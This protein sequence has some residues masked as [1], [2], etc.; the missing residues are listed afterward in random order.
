[1]RC[2]TEDSI[3]AEATTLLRHTL[4]QVPESHGIDHAIRVLDHVKHALAVEPQ[5]APADMNL[6]IMLAALLH[7]ADDRKFFGPFSKNAENILDQVLEI[8]SPSK[9]R[10]IKEET[11]LS[12]SLVSASKNGNTIPVCAQKNPLL[13]FPRHADRIEATGEIGILRC[14]QYSLERGRP[15]HVETTPRPTTV[16]EVMDAATP[17]R[18]LTYQSRGESDSMID[19]VLDKLIHLVN[20]LAKH[21][22]TYFNSIGGNNLDPLLEICLVKRPV[23]VLS[24]IMLAKKRSDHA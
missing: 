17:D 9:A 10:A 6:S 23:G 15:L 7:D 8:L 2:S 5:R 3:I 18:F 20:P 12:I 4:R 16:S 24:R 13:L 11:L 21:P 19:H 22:N 1:M 14:W